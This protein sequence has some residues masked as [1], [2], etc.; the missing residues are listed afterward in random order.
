MLE[1]FRL[2]FLVCLPP[3]NFLPL[4]SSKPD[5]DKYSFV[6]CVHVL[7]LL[8]PQKF[9]NIHRKSFVY[10]KGVQDIVHFP[11]GELVNFPDYDTTSTSFVKS[12][13]MTEILTQDEL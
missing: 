11:A 4:L 3:V 9:S 7:S 6:C 13:N 10:F 12:S 1:C 2:K 8:S 5:F